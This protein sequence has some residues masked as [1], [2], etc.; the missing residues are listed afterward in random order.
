[1][2]FAQDAV[3]GAIDL[4]DPDRIVLEYPRAMLHLTECIDPGYED[5]FVVGHGVGT[6]PGRLQE[7]RLRV[8]EL[9]EDVAELSAAYFGYRG[10]R[11]AI[12]D[13][14]ILLERETSRSLDFI[15]VDAFTADGVPSSLVSPD[16]FRMGRGK[17][18]ERGAMLLNV[19]GRGT[20]DRFVAA[21]F[22]ALRDEF[23]FA[24]AFVL[25]AAGV[26]EARNVLLVGGS[27]PIRYQAR[28]MAGFVEVD[29]PRS[30]LV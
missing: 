15:V 25:P 29:A 7:K 1:M 4:N 17:L 10:A 16:F 28:R 13:G 23:A 19:T 11:P 2:A 12:G 8:A 30:G 5:V 20:R 6:M 26:A 9:D 21:A 14:A 22:A 18:D 3:Q 27:A 24:K